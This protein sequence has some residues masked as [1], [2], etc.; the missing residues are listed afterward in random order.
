MDVHFYGLEGSE[1]EVTI[2]KSV[3]IR[4]VVLGHS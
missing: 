3:D 2:Y 1:I 4:G